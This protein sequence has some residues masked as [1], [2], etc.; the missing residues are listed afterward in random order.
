MSECFK[1]RTRETHAH[2]CRDLNGPLHHHLSKTYGL[3]RNS[4]LNTSKFFHVTDG[5]SPDIMHD[6]LEG[7]LQYEI[8]ELLKYLILEKRLF[9]LDYINNRIE[10]FPY[11]YVDST[12]K[13]VPI[14]MSS[15]TSSDHSLKQN[16]EYNSTIV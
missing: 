2:H 4:L 7:C 5:L 3:Q 1:P 11:F 14:S 16:G 6:V 13:P 9:T 10:H 12:N 8:K 15:L